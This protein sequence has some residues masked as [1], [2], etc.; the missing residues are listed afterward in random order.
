M[1]GK[2]PLPQPAGNG[3]SQSAQK[4]VGILFC[5]DTLVR[6][7]HLGVHLEI[8]T[9]LQSY[10][11]CSFSLDCVGAQACFLM[12]GLCISHCWTSLGS[13]FCFF[14]LTRSLCMATFLFSI[15]VTTL[16]FMVPGNLLKVYFCTLPSRSLMNVFN[17]AEGSIDPWETQAVHILASRWTSCHWSQWS[18]PRS[19]GCFQCTLM[20]T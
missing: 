19:S 15:S 11:L 7:E 5:K 8:R 17:I 14:T 6:H 2:D 20:S 13:Y 18:E 1:E 3:F 9:S 10:F 12:S 4:M 16:S